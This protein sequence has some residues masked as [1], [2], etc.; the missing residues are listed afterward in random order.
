MVRGPRA[1]N[2]REEGTE[3][4]H[5]AIPTHM[6]SEYYEI[7]FITKDVTCYV[8]SRIITMTEVSVCALA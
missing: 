6:E 4:S 8:L 2:G 5:Q 7:L 3:E 1:D